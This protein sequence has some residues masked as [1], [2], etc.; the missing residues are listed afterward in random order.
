M[1]LYAS[2]AAYIAYI[3][4]IIPIN[5]NTVVVSI[6]RIT[7]IIKNMMLFVIPWPPYN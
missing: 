3:S 6:P 2:Y 7:A 1:Y 4:D 5:E